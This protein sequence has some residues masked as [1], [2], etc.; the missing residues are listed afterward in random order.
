MVS[1]FGYSLDF[2]YKCIVFD[3]ENITEYDGVVR[4]EDFFRIQLF[5]IFVWLFGN[6]FIINGLPYNFFLWATGYGFTSPE[7]SVYYPFRNYSVD[8]SG[9]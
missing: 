4:L 2:F 7:E 1:Q 9:W 5:S 6:I 8:Y 3:Y